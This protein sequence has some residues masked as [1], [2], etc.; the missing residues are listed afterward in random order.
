MNYE[1][2]KELKEAG[3]KH[4]WTGNGGEVKCF[5]EVGQQIRSGYVAEEFVPPEAIPCPTLSELIEACGEEFLGLFKMNHPNDIG[6]WGVMR[7]GVPVKK[8]VEK[9]GNT[10]LAA[11]FESST[12]EEAVARLWLALNEKCHCS[13]RVEK[14]YCVVHRSDCKLN[15]K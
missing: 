8:V 11:Q 15:E 10:L 3:F 9:N 7:A 4:N 12:P 6:K 14:E 13:G 2:A 1:L 5:Y